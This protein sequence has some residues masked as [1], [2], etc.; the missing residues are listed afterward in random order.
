[1]ILPLQK[2]VATKI[3]QLQKCQYVKNTQKKNNKHSENKSKITETPVDMICESKMKKKCSAI[4]FRE[5]ARQKPLIWNTP[6]QKN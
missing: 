4:A 6:S 2:S 1:M 3:K 5:S